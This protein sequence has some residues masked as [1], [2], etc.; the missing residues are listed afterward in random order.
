MCHSSLTS[1]SLELALIF[2]RDHIRI[3]V[4]AIVQKHRESLTEKATRILDIGKYH[5]VRRKSLWV[6]TEFK[7]FDGISDGLPFRQNSVGFRRKSRRF[8]SE[9]KVDLE[10]C[11]RPRAFKFWGGSCFASNF[12]LERE[13]VREREGEGRE[14][15]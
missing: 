8:P 3:C 9:K 15:K 11:F 2:I 14:R 10:A 1:F 7:I 6:P 12:I 13:G 5:G 4:W